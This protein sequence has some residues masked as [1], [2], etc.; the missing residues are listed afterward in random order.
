MI[1]YDPHRWHTTF[2]TVRGS[3]VKVIS[4][5][6]SLVAMIAL[7]LTIV[8]FHLY[9]F[10]FQNPLVVHGF[11]G[12]ALGLLLVFRTNA[13]YDRWWEGRKLWGAMV[14]TCRNLT[15]SASV[16]LAHDPVV[17]DRV[18][19]LA[20]CFPE[21]TMFALR[22]EDWTPSVQLDP[23][24]LE[25]VLGKAHRPLSIC[26]RITWLLEHER[27]NGRLSDIVFTSVDANNQQLI[28]IV[29]ACERIHKTPL[30]FAYVVH[31]RRALI[32]F[33]GTLPVGLVEIFGWANVG[34]VFGVAYIMLGIEEIGVEIEDPFER[35]DNDLPL[36]Q[37]TSGIQGV[38]GS[39]LPKK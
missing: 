39:Y 16:H 22:G 37:I 15:R 35:D 8:H 18:I 12:T 5:R 10:Q 6:A 38:I 4:M 23:L 30:P 27:K 11:V 26:Q 24:D 21:A 36:E 31:L 34:I 17:L 25:A 28:D 29:G 13:S 7:L 20:Q 2:F 1:D 14:N 33:C 32:L 3:M 19:R 9:R